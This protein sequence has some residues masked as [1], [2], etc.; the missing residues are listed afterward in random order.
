M[1]IDTTRYSLGNVFRKARDLFSQTVTPAVNRLDADKQTAGFQFRTPQQRQVATQRQQQVGSYIQGVGQRIQQAPQVFRQDPNRFNVFAAPKRMYTQTPP[2]NNQVVNDVSKATGGFVQNKIFQ[3]M[4]DIPKNLNTVR[5]ETPKIFNR[6]LAGLERWGAAANVGIAGMS[7]VGA[8]IPGLDDLVFGGYD[9]LKGY[10]ASRTRGERGYQNAQGALRSLSGE[11]SIGAGDAVT[12]NPLAQKVLNTAELPALLLAGNAKG[13]LKRPKNAAKTIEEITKRGEA[14][15]IQGVSPRVNKVHPE[16]L[17]VMRQFADE[18]LRNK[19]SKK[20]LGDLGVSAQRLAEHYFGGDWKYA[21]NKKLAQAFEW[22]IDL[23]M[24]IPREARGKLPSPNLVEDASQSVMSQLKNKPANGLEATTQP[25][26]VKVAKQLALTPTQKQLLE[27]SEQKLVGGER[28]LQQTKQGL[29]SS[30][31][32]P[33]GPTPPSRRTQLQT[34]NQTDNNQYSYSKVDELYTQFVDRFHPLSKLAKKGKKDTQMA[35]SLAKYYGSGSTATF[36]LEEELA[37]ILKENNL[38][39][40]KQAAIAMRDIE[41]ESRG[42]KGSQQQKQ[43]RQ[44][45]QEMDQ[46]LGRETMQ[47][48]GKTMEKLYAYQ[49]TM[50]KQYL[51]DTGILSQETYNAM[52]Q[53]NQF[54]IPMKR[55][56]DDVDEMLG[57]PVKRGAGSVG[58]Q[59]VIFGIKG[60]DKEIVDPVESIIENTYKLVSLGRRQQVAQT[61]A[62]LSKEF[63]ELVKKTNISDQR[64]TISLFENGKKVHYIVPP[65]LAEAAR[66]M[67]EEQLIVLAKILK[68]PTDL[69]RTMTTGINPEFVVPNLFR[70]LQSAGTNTG[71]NPVK[72]LAGFAHYIKQDDVYKDFM[73]SGGMTSRISMNKDFIKQTAEELTNQKALTIKSPKDII[74]GLEILGQYSEQPTRLAVFE[75][76]YKKALKAGLSQED[77]LDEAAYWSQEGTVNFARR[78]SKMSNINAI[79][80]YLNARIQGVDRMLRSAKSNPGAFATRVGVGFVGPSLALYAWNSQ[81]PDYYNDRIISERDKRDNFIFM[82]PGEGSYGVRYLKIPKAEVGKVVNPIESFLDYSRGRGGDVW[83]TAQDFL[84]SFLPIDDVGSTIPTAIKPLV[85]QS[86]NKN[87][88]FGTEIVPDYKQDYPAG[89][90]DTNYTAPLYRMIGQNT[91][92]SP[93]RLQHFS[94]SYLG[95]LGRLAEIS[96]RPLIS[97]QYKTKENNRGAGINQTPIVRRFAGGEKMSQEEYLQKQNSKNKAIQRK[98]STLQNRALDGTLPP[99]KADAQIRKLQEQATTPESVTIS[100]LSNA[101]LYDKYMDLGLKDQITPEMIVEKYTKDLTFTPSGSKYQDAI[102]E[103]K[104]WDA[105]GRINSSESLSDGQK[106][107]AIAQMLDKAG[108]DTQDYQYYQVAKQENDLKTMFAIEE[109]TKVMTAP[110]STKESVLEWLKANR[111]EFRG[112]MVLSSGVIDNLVDE[113]LISYD[114]GKALKKYTFDKDKTTGQYI[115]KSG[116]KKGGTRVRAPKPKRI[117]LKTI[118]P[119]KVKTISSSGKKFK[120]PKIKAVDVRLK[121]KK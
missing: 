19:G 33:G 51:V 49:D 5:T 21:N 80:A 14:L 81:F 9:A 22:A 67:G 24:N 42:I 35:R 119:P 76:A 111:Y 29:Q 93:A 59:N 92:V 66:G 98:I 30:Q 55:V 106:T 31:T 26:M 8:L 91:N 32:L 70:D 105:L 50:V 90:Q 18:V 78:G 60:S 57:I 120:A 96:T 74:R 45:L 58:K 47:S 15:G 73:R 11:D 115:V 64:N 1:A 61:I 17:D 117:K 99:S 89:F 94:E 88:Y 23:N 114:E 4:L 68:L 104:V 113:G 62:G 72:W 97:D 20:A 77:A 109:L 53:N 56:M 40:L 7:T 101:A 46:R 71:L 85:E 54:Y 79:Y 102:N 100:G 3:P 86:Q 95:G 103:D 27:R 82:L 2:T 44:I 10:S 41:L 48:L 25:Q 13:M 75:D 69:F 65:E 83:S 87:F 52:R 28:L 63:P 118:K 121:I 110:G 37:P 108:I 84:V 43:A 39:D 12:N 107:Q 34:E 112:K 116:K 16:D 6:N 38:A 36:H